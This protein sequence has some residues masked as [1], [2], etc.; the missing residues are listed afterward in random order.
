MK[1]GILLTTSPENENTSTVIAVSDA[2]R[3]QG[4]EVSIFLMYDGVYNIHRKE[5]VALLDKGVNITV[6]TFNVE[7]RN[8]GRVKGILFG[9]QYDHAC[10][11]NDVDRFVSFGQP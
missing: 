11:A 1:L 8:V 5:F 6:C 7:Q 4:H 9:S 10:I 2:A 3:R